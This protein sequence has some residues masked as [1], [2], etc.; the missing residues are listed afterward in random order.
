VIEDLL[1]VFVDNQEYLRL[2]LEYLIY[3]YGISKA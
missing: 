2:Y 1:E 3:S